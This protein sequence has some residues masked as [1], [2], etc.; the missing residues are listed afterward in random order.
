MT[1]TITR[2]FARYIALPIVSAGIIG[3]AALGMAGMAS[4][5]TQTQPT[6]PGYSYAPSVKAHFAPEGAA[7]LARPPRREPHRAPG[8]RL[9]PLIEPTT[10]ALPEMG[11]ASLFGSVRA[12]DRR[13]V[14]VVADGHR[15]VDLRNRRHACVGEQL[16]GRRFRRLPAPLRQ[17]GVDIVAL[18]RFARLIAVE[19]FLCNL[20]SQAARAGAAA[21]RPLV[22]PSVPRAWRP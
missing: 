6:G 13:A 19:T 14:V 10:E 3:G 20:R 21:P 12:L 5:A 7:G 22:L 11:R 9:P 18:V 1:T 15:A 17:I 16:M 2:S 8:S 4:A